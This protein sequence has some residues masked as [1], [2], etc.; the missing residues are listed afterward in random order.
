MP[1]LHRRVDTPHTPKEMYDLVMAIDTYPEFLPWCTGL[2]I[3][4]HAVEDGLEKMTAD[5]MVSFKVLS[6]KFTSQVNG[7]EETH[8]IDID[9]ID[10]VGTVE[11]V[12]IDIGELRCIGYPCLNREAEC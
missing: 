2:R 8:T 11:I 7:R 9:Y 6:E 1:K 12:D 3:R 10:V 4:T 5:M